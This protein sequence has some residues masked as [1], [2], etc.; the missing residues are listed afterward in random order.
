MKNRFSIRNVFEFVSRTL[1]YLFQKITKFG[2]DRKFEQELKCRADKYL[3]TSLESASPNKFIG[4]VQFTDLKLQDDSR[5]TICREDIYRRF[6]AD[7]DG[8]DTDHFGR[9]GYWVPRGCLV[10][11]DRL[12][13][14]YIKVVD[15][16][17]CRR[18]T[19][20]FL[21]DALERGLYDF[22]CP[23]L[24]YVI[25]D[26]NN[27]IRGY[28]IREGRQL[29]PYEFEIYVSKCLRELICEMT[30]RTGLYFYDLTYHNVILNERTLSFI[31]LESVLPVHWFGKGD[32]F[33]LSH[34]SDID[35]GWPIQKKWHSPIWYSDWLTHLHRKEGLANR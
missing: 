4:N 22:L 32:D 9:N 17:Y 26:C 33:S 28:A 13:N 19:G 27:V 20:R 5:Y 8:S 18:G 2:I 34:L 3:A 11:F 14:D 35:I 31:D 10:Y 25:R 15:A 24:S 29:T 12:T 16:Y 30:R 7:E 1:Y 21:E 6:V 23:S